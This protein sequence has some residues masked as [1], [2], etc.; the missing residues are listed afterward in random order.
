MILWTRAPSELSMS[1]EEHQYFTLLLALTD[2]GRLTFLILLIA[3]ID[4]SDIVPL[5]LGL[6]LRVDFLALG[7]VDVGGV[8][9]TSKP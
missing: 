9:H 7:F 1:D 2:I 3:L 4:I 6:A 5:G 8:Y